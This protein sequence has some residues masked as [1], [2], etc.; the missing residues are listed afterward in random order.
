MMRTLSGLLIA[1]I[2]L[3]ACRSTPSRKYLEKVAKIDF[4]RDVETVETADNGEFECAGFFRLSKND[5]RYFREH[6]AFKILEQPLLRDPST[7]Y[8][9][10]LMQDTAS[11]FRPSGA[12]ISWY[13]CNGCADIT[14]YIDTLQLKMWCVAMY[15][16]P[17]GDFCC[18]DTLKAEPAAAPGKK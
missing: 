1:C 17:A 14:I 13:R 8:P 3:P 11:C 7:M 5:L 9:N 18:G 6:A 16:D 15:P 12:M 10:N 4:P 2:L